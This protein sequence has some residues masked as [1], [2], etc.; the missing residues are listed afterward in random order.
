MRTG[1]TLE[2]GAKKAEL[3]PTNADTT[4]A[5]QLLTYS[6]RGSMPAG[7]FQRTDVTRLVMTFGRLEDVPPVR[8]ALFF[9]PVVQVI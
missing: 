6:L 9:E 1:A 8:L 3:E 2:V 5:T 4:E 7:G